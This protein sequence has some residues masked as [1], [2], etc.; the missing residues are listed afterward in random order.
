MK[1][2]IDRGSFR[3]D[4]LIV[5]GS[6]SLELVAGMERFPG[7]RGHGRDIR[8]H[9]LSFGEYVEHFAGVALKKA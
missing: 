4:V 2:R 7:R 9:P 8:M 6:A 1:S 5:T 3:S